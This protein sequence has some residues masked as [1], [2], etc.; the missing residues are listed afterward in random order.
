MNNLIEKI[1][2][3]SVLN[4]LGKNGGF[5]KSFDSLDEEVVFNEILYKKV[6]HDMQILKEVI[7]GKDVEGDVEFWD[8]EGNDG[9]IISIAVDELGKHQD[10]VAKYINLEDI[11]I[12]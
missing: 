7:F 6:N 9:N 11:M 2:F 8:Y 4:I 12:K 5:L 3:A 1:N 10:V